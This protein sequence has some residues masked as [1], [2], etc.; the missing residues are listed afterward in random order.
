MYIIELFLTITLVLINPPIIF[1]INHLL[2]RLSKYGES[3]ISPF[4]SDQSDVFK[5]P[6][7]FNQ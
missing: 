3:H 7:H 5:S 2:F 1:K 4:S 6:R